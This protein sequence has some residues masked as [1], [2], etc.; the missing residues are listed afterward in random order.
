MRAYV[1]T[2]PGAGAVQEV[3]EPELGAYDAAV[4]LLWCGVCSST[5]RMLRSGTFRGGVS[6]P[7]ILGHESVGRVSALGPG[8]RSLEVGDVVTRPAA[9]SAAAAPLGMH[10]GGFAERGVVTD[11]PAFAA[12]H[13]QAERP[14]VAPWVRLPPATD[15]AVAS[16]AISLAET[17]SVACRE[18]LLGRTVVVVGTGVAGL[19]LLRFARLL[20]AARV[21]AVGRRPERLALAARFGADDGRPADDPLA[22][23]SSADVV[24]EASGQAAMVDDAYRWLRPGGR[25][26]IYSAPEA[27]AAI[28]LM[29]APRDAQLVV[30]STHEQAVLAQVVTMVEAGLLPLE[31]FVT[32]TDDLDRI[33]SVFEDIDDGSVVKALVRL[34]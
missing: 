30:S 17:W 23:R 18:D 32:R 12:D 2:G 15:P 1:M 25:L 29:A 7:S 33:G 34:G 26:V 16:L 6:Y 21:V 20:G 8:V 27:P 31:D 3:P 24:F 22:L 11:W 9:Y 13:P 14:A 28:D 4:D 10:W 19:S 5:D